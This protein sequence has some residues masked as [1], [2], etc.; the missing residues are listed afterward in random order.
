MH[1]HTVA[2]RMQGA[3]IMLPPS[4]RKSC[5]PKVAAPESAASDTVAHAQ[6]MLAQGTSVDWNEVLCKEL[7]YI[8]LLDEDDDVRLR[9][10]DCEDNI[11]SQ[12]FRA[13]QESL[14]AVR[15]RSEPVRNKIENGL[16]RDMAKIEHKTHIE[17]LNG[18]LEREYN[19]GEK[20][21]VVEWRA[22]S[23]LR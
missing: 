2:Q 16:Q 21:G 14:R 1:H 19:R 3:L 11:N 7:V 13:A 15:K 12:H 22:Q 6:R 8:G 17:E 18:R 4:H 5:P 20:H 9:L 23:R 10:R